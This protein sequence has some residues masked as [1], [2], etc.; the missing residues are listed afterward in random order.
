[1]IYIHRFGASRAPLS[2]WRGRLGLILAT[3]LGLAVALALIAFS[4]GLAL[5][6][7]P[8]VGLAWLFR[9]PLLRRAQRRMQEEAARH[10]GRERPKAARVIE[11]DYE[12][13]PPDSRGERRP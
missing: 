13:L 4:L 11:V 8:I 9:G 5:V 1:M 6:L 7:V 2:G 10:G 3:A 12:V